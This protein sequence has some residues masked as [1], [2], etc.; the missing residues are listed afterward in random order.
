MLFRSNF[1]QDSPKHTRIT[2][3]N[4]SNDLSVIEVGYNK[5][6][7]GKQQILQREVYI[8][9]YCIGGK[10][11][12]QGEEFDKGF[13]YLTV[14]G[15]TEIICADENDPYETYWVI[16]RGSSAPDILRLCG[17][18]CKCG[19]YPFD[20][21]EECAEIL[22]KA[23]YS[24]KSDGDMAEVF[25]LL[26]A[27]HAVMAVHMESLGKVDGKSGNVA[28]DVA[29]FLS[30]NYH[31]DIKIDEIA[32]TFNYSR[33]HLYALFKKEYGVSPKEYLI[34]LRIEKA[35]QFLE[36]KS[37]ELSVKEIAYAIGFH[38]PF[39]FSKLFSS[40]V[41]VSPLQYKKNYDPYDTDIK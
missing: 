10:G 36:D 11:I 17:L 16:F 4:F 38:D 8:L 37:L 27:F 5:V 35:R 6:P 30:K 21:N 23:L 20:K 34:N 1:D 31:C 29:E 24:T 19:V 22:K 3:I 32:E 40:K 15:E 39:Y 13:L 12:F 14:P 28:K 2:H 26:S 7:K 33:N 9:H 25:S 41:G 18:P